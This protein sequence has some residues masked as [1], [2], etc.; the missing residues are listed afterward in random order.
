VRF[1]PV[2]AGNQARQP[3]PIKLEEDEGAPP[4]RRTWPRATYGRYGTPS[5]PF[6]PKQLL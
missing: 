1:V 2:A 6:A 5:I 4:P 3:P